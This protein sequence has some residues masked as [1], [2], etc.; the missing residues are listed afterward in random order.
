MVGGLAI[1]L[2]AVMSDRAFGPLLA[3]VGAVVQHLRKL[4]HKSAVVRQLTGVVL[5]GV[6][7]GGDE[8]VQETVAVGAG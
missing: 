3:V 8:G 5:G 6:E 1:R 4:E 2:K 7:G